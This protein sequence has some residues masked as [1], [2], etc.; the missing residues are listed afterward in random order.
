MLQHTKSLKQEHQ[1]LQNQSSP[2]DH[3]IYV[4]LEDSY[5]DNFHLQEASPERFI[6]ENIV[7]VVCMM[8]RRQFWFQRMKKVVGWMNMI[9]VIVKKQERILQ[10]LRI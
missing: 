7:K 1:K 9:I 10:K 5:H 6:K 2:T 3:L 4:H 8:E